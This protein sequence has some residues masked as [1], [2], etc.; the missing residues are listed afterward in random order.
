MLQH[1]AKTV[2]ICDCRDR[3]NPGDRHYINIKRPTSLLLLAFIYILYS[4]L[5]F[6][7]QY[8]LF[9]MKDSLEKGQ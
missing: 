6:Q 8:F 2:E 1:T 9:F 5:A 4:I 7:T 3:V